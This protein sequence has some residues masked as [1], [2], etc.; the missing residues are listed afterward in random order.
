MPKDPQVSGSEVGWSRSKT[1]RKNIKAPEYEDDGDQDGSG[2]SV[3]DLKYLYHQ[4]G[5]RDFIRQD[6]VMKFLKQKRIADPVVAE[7]RDTGS[8]DIEMESIRSSDRGSNWEYAP[9]DIEF[10]APAQAAVATA[11]SGSTGSTRIQRVRISAISELK[12]FSGKDPNDDRSLVWISKVKSAFTQ[13][14]ASDEENCL[15]FADL[16]AGSE[17]NWI[18]DGSTNDRREHVDHFIETWEDPDQADRLTLLRLSDA[19]D[20]EE[21]LRARDRVKTRQKNAAFGSGKF[22]QKAPNAAPSAPAKQVRAIRIQAVDSGSDTSN[23]LDGS[24]SEMCSHRRIYLAANQ[25]VAPK[26]EKRDDH[27]GSGTSGSGIHEP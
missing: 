7:P 25:E 1:V 4:K 17:K 18:K 21:A 13:D 15:T 14:Q 11:A 22:R 12:K 26:R 19:D 9:D 6:P 5:L 27:V 10:P 16:L 2:W 3:E 8:R 24:D 23:G 20:L